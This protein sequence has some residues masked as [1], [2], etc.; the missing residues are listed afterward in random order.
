MC[1]EPRELG[2]QGSQLGDAGHGQMQESLAATGRGRGL[3][4]VLD[5]VGSPWRVSRMRVTFVTQV[6]Q[7]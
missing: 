4:C 6:V 3:D 7:R 1:L 2:G 5:A